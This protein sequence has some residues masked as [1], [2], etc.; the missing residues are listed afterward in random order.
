MPSTTIEPPMPRRPLLLATLLLLLAA[1][2][3]LAQD[4]PADPHDGGFLDTVSRTMF[5]VNRSLYSGLSAAG[6][7]LSGPSAADMASSALGRGI[8][9]VA[10]N[11]VNEPVTAVSGLVTG[12][13]ETSWHATKRF[14]INS[15]FGLLGWHDAAAES[16]G[17][18][19]RHEDI[20][21]LLCRAG[22]GEGGYVVLP[23]I[24]PRTL[25]DGAADIVVTN[26][27]L[28]SM[29]GVALGTGISW[30]TIV[31]AE[32]IEIVA[33][34][35]ATRQMDSEAAEMRFG[36]YDQMRAAYLAQRRHRCSQ[37]ETPAG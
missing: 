13:L 21:L 5:T 7:W 2:P 12:S 9:N 28:W 4:R 6:D 15:T 31:I 10:S 11:L 25:R 32:S 14:A 18:P 34:I 16:W 29:A 33:D 24:G 19:R 26:A 20:G 37:P 3:A 8:G 36:D 23:L 30:Q 17:L 27:V 1:A 35:L 22:L